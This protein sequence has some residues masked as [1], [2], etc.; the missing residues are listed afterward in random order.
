MFAQSCLLGRQRFCACAR[1]R[2]FSTSL[3]EGAETRSGH[4]YSRI[5]SVI[6]LWFENA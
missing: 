1:V 5:Q 4:F 3:L 6:S 2:G